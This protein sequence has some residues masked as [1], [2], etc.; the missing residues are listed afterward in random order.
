M[1]PRLKVSF[2]RKIHYLTYILFN[3]KRNVKNAN[4]CFPSGDGSFSHWIY[5]HPCSVTCGKGLVTRYRRC[6]DPIP[7]HGGADCVGERVETMSCDMGAC[8]SEYD[9]MYTCLHKY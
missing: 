9:N 4:N 3:K 2:I 1:E 7:K 5:T 6:D 8:P